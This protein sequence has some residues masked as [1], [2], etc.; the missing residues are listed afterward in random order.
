MN[1]IYSMQLILLNIGYAIHNADWNYKNVKS[2]FARIYLVKEGYARLHLPGN[3]IQDLRPN[4]LYM[5]PPFTM[6]SYECTNHFTLYYIHI[7][8][9]Q[10]SDYFILEDLMYPVEIKAKNIDE[11]LVE[12]LFTINPD[13][14][15]NHNDPKK[16]DNTTNLIKTINNQINRATHDLLETNGILFQLL[17]HFMVY[18]KDKYDIVDNRILRVVKYIRNNI[19]KDISIEELKDMCCLSKDHFIRLFK[20]DLQE[21]PTQY[22]IQRKI[23][24]AQLMLITSDLLIKDI[25]Y[26]LSFENVYYFNRLF[27][28]ATGFTPS[29]YRKRV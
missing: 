7:Y 8:D 28:K 26:E 5:I 20:N 10:K 9:N 6:H 23:E 17:S 16:Y 24:R 22:I 27:K 29:D 3:R 25:A 11:L 19:H 1:E 14:A 2:P 21:T 4:H 18:S 12:R 15:L 13:S